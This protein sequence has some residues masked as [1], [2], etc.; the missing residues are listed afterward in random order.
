[1]AFDGDRLTFARQAQRKD[2]DHRCICCSFARRRRRRRR[3]PRSTRQMTTALDC[4]SFLNVIFEMIH[5]HCSEQP[6][7]PAVVIIM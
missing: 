2:Y 7:S 3:R 4:S 1:M 6:L 5:G